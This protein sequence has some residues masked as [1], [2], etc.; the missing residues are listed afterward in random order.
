M[1]YM[2]SLSIE[3]EH[4]KTLGNRNPTSVGDF[5]GIRRRHILLKHRFDGGDAD[6]MAAAHGA[7]CIAWHVT[8]TVSCDPAKIISR[9]AAAH[10]VVCVIGLMFHS[11]SK[12]VMILVNKVKNIF[13]K[14]VGPVTK[15]ES[16]CCVP[17]HNSIM[18]PIA[19][20]RQLG[21]SPVQDSGMVFDRLAL[22]I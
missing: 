4:A 2:D 13:I 1:N 11:H 8:A 18:H 19:L 20:V 16:V 15:F 21:S 9:I 3:F 6:E 7:S 17:V 12:S 22:R 5:L 10:S 14:I